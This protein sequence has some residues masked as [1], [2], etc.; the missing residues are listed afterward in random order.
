MESLVLS[1]MRISDATLSFH[2]QRVQGDIA[3]HPWD[4]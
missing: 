4:A 2:A 3:M 1:A